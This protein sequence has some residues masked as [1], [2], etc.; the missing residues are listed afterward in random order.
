[1][2]KEQQRVKQETASQYQRKFAE[3]EKEKERYVRSYVVGRQLI[4]CIHLN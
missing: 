4:L 1:M 3:L 2:Q